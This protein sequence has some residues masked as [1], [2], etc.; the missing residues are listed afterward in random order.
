MNNYLRE[1]RAFIAINWKLIVVAAAIAMVV[2]VL[3]ATGNLRGSGDGKGSNY[4]GADKMAYDLGHDC[5][6]NAWRTAANDLS[7]QGDPAA[8]SESII[9]ACDRVARWAGVSNA[10]SSPFHQ[11]FGDGFAEG[12]PEP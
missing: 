5:A 2:A 11:G 3:V 6:Q 10:A 9:S 1:T 12:V 4:S 8:A 7:A